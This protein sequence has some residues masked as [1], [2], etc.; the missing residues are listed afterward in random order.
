MSEKKKRGRL[1]ELIAA[2][3]DLKGQNKAI[4]GETLTVFK[5]K[6]AHF[7]E[8]MK[9]FTATAEEEK[10]FEG[11]KEHTPMIT[12]VPARLQ[13]QSKATAKYIDAMIQQESANTQAKSDI[14]LSDGTVI[15]E[16][17]PV[18][19]LLGLERELK[20]QRAVYLAIPTLDPA[21]VWKE[22]PSQ[23]KDI[24]ECIAPKVKTT[25]KIVDVLTKAP[26]T[27]KHP[28]QTELINKDVVIGFTEMTT[29]SSK[30]TS[31]RKHELLTRL[32]DMISAVKRA[33]ARA[34]Q[35]EVEDI[36]VGGKM[37]KYLNDGTI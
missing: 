16:N 4:T 23:G 13:Y 26:A 6:S 33:R 35:Q 20:S 24:V 12:T 22:A 25:K 3:E 21:K 19:A 14:I 37:F 5:N 8:T 11:L 1:H 18:T 28:A 17:L 36:K 30:L 27:D 7:D 31:A 10:P 2:Q 32:D 15:A 34:N 29:R 9:T